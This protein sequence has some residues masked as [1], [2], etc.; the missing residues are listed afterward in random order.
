MSHFINLSCPCSHRPV[1]T[2]QPSVFASDVSESGPVRWPMT[3]ALLSSPRL[4]VFA[5][6]SR[7]FTLAL[8]AWLTGDWHSGLAH[9]RPLMTVIQSPSPGTIMWHPRDTPP[10]SSDLLR[11]RVAALQADSCEWIVGPLR[12]PTSGRNSFSRHGWHRQIN[13][14]DIKGR[15]VDNNTENEGDNDL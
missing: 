11:P 4:P 5:F 15:S 7:W 6:Q 3:G 9:S 10:L 2:H 13:D 14:T 12:A 8:A 1:E